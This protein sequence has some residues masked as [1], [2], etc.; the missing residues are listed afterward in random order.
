MG[1]FTM[2]SGQ[3]IFSRRLFLVY[4]GGILFLPSLAR[5]DQ[6]YAK[7]TLLYAGIGKANNGVISTLQNHLN[8]TTTSFGYT[9]DDFSAKPVDQFVQ[10]YV[11][12]GNENMGVCSP[13]SNHLN[14]AT[15][16]VGFL[17]I[18][19]IVVGMR[20][21]YVGIGKLNNGVVTPNQMH[22]ND[23]TRELGYALP[24]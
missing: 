10:I 22:L 12:V 14:G 7:S 16:P 5:A 13:N 24:V 8:D 2:L 15:Q 23:T 18:S 19:P 21:L 3:A 6:T 11:G 9:I 17:S 4:A 1:K 20:K